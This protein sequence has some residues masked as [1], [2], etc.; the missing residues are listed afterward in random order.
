MIGTGGTGV[1][2]PRL[3]M[4]NAGRRLA[5]SKRIELGDEMVFLILGAHAT[6][7]H[8]P[9]HRQTVP[10]DRSRARNGLGGPSFRRLRRNSRIRISSP[11]EKNGERPIRFLTL[12]PL[13]ISGCNCQVYGTLPLVMC[14]IRR[15][16]VL[17]GVG[18]VSAKAGEIARE[19]ATYRCE[20]CDLRVP[21]HS[22]VPIDDCPNCGCPSFQ[23]GLASQP[24][25]SPSIITGII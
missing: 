19:N 22:G 10:L 23:T 6:R 7:Q 17:R 2:L 11:S 24:R 13:T 3:Y 15:R 20:S 5:R 14:S 8:R 25:R 18:G 1:C 21:V 9:V 4:K 16:E 12:R